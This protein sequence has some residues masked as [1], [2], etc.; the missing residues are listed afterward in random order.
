MLVLTFCP[1]YS[2]TLSEDDPNF[3]SYAADIDDEPGAQIHYYQKCARDMLADERKTLYVD[4]TH[5]SSYQWDDPQFMDHLQ[6]EYIRY[7][8]YLRQGLTHFLA[9]QEH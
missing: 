5:M 1:P 3:E 8:P 6:G 7:E 2:F 4:F 9:D